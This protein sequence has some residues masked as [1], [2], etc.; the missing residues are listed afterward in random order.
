M[1]SGRTHYD[2][3]H[4]T[5]DAPPELVRAAYR[6][7][8]QSHHPDKRPADA[9]AAEAMARINRAYAVLRSASKRRSYDAW[10]AANG[11]GEADA[12]GGDGGTTQAWQAHRQ[13]QRWGRFAA[14]LALVFGVVILLSRPS[15]P[16]FAHDPP[17]S[18][19]HDPLGHPWPA[20]G[21]YISGMA[22]RSRGG[23]SKIVIDNSSSDGPVY[24]KLVDIARMGQGAQRHFFVPAGER[25]E[26]ED[27]ADGNYEVRY[28]DLDSGTRARTQAFI[29]GGR[30]IAGTPRAN[31]V[32]VSLAEA[33]AAGRLE[34]S[35]L[36][37]E[38]F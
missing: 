19:S 27:V 20:D 21:G 6:A 17:A 24:G 9:E 5:R 4:L 29:I 30:T 34:S 12:W 37:E 22:I 11:P 32:T 31:L 1:T 33:A 26:L 38:D 25:F 18:A 13:T 8:S 14:L 35:P 23:E 36:A 7:L 16:A 2:V 10:L 3:L 15:S 28:Q